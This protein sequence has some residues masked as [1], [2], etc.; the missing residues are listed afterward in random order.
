MLQAFIVHIRVFFESTLIVY[1]LMLQP[2]WTVPVQQHIATSVPAPTTVPVP[3]APAPA[4]ATCDWTEH[5]SPEGHKYYYNSST[6]E[7]RVRSFLLASARLVY[8]MM[9][10]WFFFAVGEA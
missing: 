6:G 7:S 1:F 9:H 2:S 5:T 4:T 8:F 10:S 3:V